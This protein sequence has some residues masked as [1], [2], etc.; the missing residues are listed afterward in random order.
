V[1]DYHSFPHELQDRHGFAG[2]PID[3]DPL[4]PAAWLS[5]RLFGGAV[6]DYPIFIG[7]DECAGTFEQVVLRSKTGRSSTFGQRRPLW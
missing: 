6:Q 4:L 2:F 7:R 1:P 5:E 3:Y